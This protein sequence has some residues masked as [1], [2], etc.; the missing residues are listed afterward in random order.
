MGVGLGC[1]L[2][3]LL[4]SS[5]R[6]EERVTQGLTLRTFLPY[7]V[8]HVVP[9]G[10]AGSR[11]GWMVR[12]AAVVA[13]TTAALG[14]GGTPS[15]AR[16]RSCV[17]RS[18]QSGGSAPTSRRAGHRLLTH[19]RGTPAALHH[20]RRTACP[21]T[22]SAAGGRY[23]PA[24]A[25]GG[26][27]W[28]RQRPKWPKRH[29]AAGPGGKSCWRWREVIGNDGDGGRMEWCGSRPRARL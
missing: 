8:T 10:W 7:W 24:A 3:D 16:A 4:P 5:P 11:G 26:R 17:N 21:R 13:A 9:A 12:R 2:C 29:R 22:H 23:H 28:R 14:V 6:W 19:L 27:R 18:T 25:C 1:A 15:A 20:C